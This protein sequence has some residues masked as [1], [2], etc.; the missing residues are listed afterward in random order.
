VE[1]RATVSS[2]L[3]RTALPEC[4]WH[5]FANGC[6]DAIQRYLRGLRDVPAVR[7]E[8]EYCTRNLGFG[9]GNNILCQMARGHQYV[10][11]LE[12][13]WV[14]LLPSEAAKNRTW[15]EEVLAYLDARPAVS[16]VLLRRCMTPC[17][18][19]Q[20]L[21]NRWTQEMGSRP[22][23]IFRGREFHYR[24]PVWT[25]N[26]HVRRDSDLW[27]ARVFPFE[28][29]DERKG[30]EQWGTTEI[31]ADKRASASGRVET[32]HLWPGVFGH[33][34]HCRSFL[35]NDTA[36]E[37]ANWASPLACPRPTAA[38]SVCKYRFHSQEPEFC[39]CCDPAKGWT[40]YTAHQERL[41]MALGLRV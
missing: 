32:R 8:I 39:A 37:A 34:E 10:L 22:G 23:E 20:F 4:T 9:Q 24:R 40:D 19:R 25:S 16:Q 1:L 33:W 7:F 11:N 21:F 2:L 6:S 38:P 35:P 31:A 12:D 18:A 3:E 13:D 36:V 27:D 5:I 41:Y 28:A 17:E 26:P 15:L 30:E 29:C 14:C